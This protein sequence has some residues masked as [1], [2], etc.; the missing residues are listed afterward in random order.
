[1]STSDRLRHLSACFTSKI[2]YPFPAI[3]REYVTCQG[4]CVGTGLWSCHLTQPPVP[5]PAAQKRRYPVE[6]SHCFY[7]AP[8]M[9]RFEARK[10]D[11]LADETKPWSLSSGKRD[12]AALHCVA[13][14]CPDHKRGIQRISYQFS[15]YIRR[16]DKAA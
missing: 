16:P 9:E 11:S 2:P 3:R 7:A 1:V 5:T 12:C 4:W 14:H 13:F 15:T 6:V 8:N 10:P